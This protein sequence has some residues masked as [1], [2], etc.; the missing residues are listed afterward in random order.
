MCQENHKGQ[1]GTQELA[2][3]TPVSV[4]V[5]EKREISELFISKDFTRHSREQIERENTLRRLYIPVLLEITYLNLII[6]K[7]DPA[8]AREHIIDKL[9]QIYS[10]AFDGLYE[11][12]TKDI[13]RMAFDI[14]DYRD[15]E[16]VYFERR[17]TQ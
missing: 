1:I 15:K 5:I 10:K 3:E 8:F 17:R 9:Y 12:D 14:K 7:I 6:Q 16:V 4:E 2:L 11:L 13:K